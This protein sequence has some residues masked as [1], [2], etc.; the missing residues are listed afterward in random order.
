[1]IV[2]N[3]DLH[4]DTYKPAQKPMFYGG[5]NHGSI[6][7][8]KGKWYIFYHRH[9]NG[10]N[11]SRQACAEPICF[12][13]DGSIPQAEMTSCGLNGGPLAGK[14]EYPAYLACNLFCSE[15]SLYTDWTASWMNNQ[16]PK[17]TQDGRDGDE[18]IGYIANMKDSATAGFKYFDCKD[19]RKI[20]IRVRGYAKGNFE[21]KTSWDGPILGRIPVE[22]SNIWKE[23]S[24]YIKIPD[25]VQ[26]LYFTFS[27]SGSASFA[28]FALE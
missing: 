25:G 19:I 23:Y 8:I 28:S 22:F 2:S 11:F 24:G 6:V 26:S 13:D 4:I 14:G 27:G 17:I 1:V 15:E 10:T 7:E 5:N 18:E 21:V 20:K 3:S 12:L 16:F 9:T